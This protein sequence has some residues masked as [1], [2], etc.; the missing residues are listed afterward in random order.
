MPVMTKTPA[1][2]EIVILS[3]AEYETL[4]TA[5]DGDDVDARRANKLI[6]ELAGDPETLSEDDMD[7]LLAAK[8]PMAFWRKHRGLTQEAL[9]KVTG[10]AQGF[11]S[12]I[13]NGTKTGDVQTVARIARALSLSI[14]DLVIERP[15]KKAR[16]A[17]RWTETKALTR[18]PDK[19]D[20][21]GTGHIRL[22]RQKR[23]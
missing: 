14:D 7:K 1:G 3:R 2:D 13:E 19:S 6:A 15:P 12:E 16:R 20:K 5:R 8:T 23:A 4:L 9:S 22:T 17:G 18:K 21:S 10:V 11:L